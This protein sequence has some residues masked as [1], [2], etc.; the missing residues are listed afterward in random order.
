MRLHRLVGLLLCGA[1]LA[2]PA[3]AE[4]A[5]E[6]ER[7]ARER[8]EARLRLEQA[9]RGCQQRFVVTACVDAARAEHRQTM[10]RLRREEAVLDEAQRR[11]RAAARLSAIEEKQRAERARDAQGVAPPAE[12]A[13]TTKMPRQAKVRSRPAAPAASAAD[14][15]AEEQRKRSR[16]EERQRAAQAHREQAQQ[17]RAQREKAGRTSAPLPDPAAR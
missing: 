2:T 16:Y 14:R 12:T 8:S 15:G 6:R 9:Q 13:P 11:Q 5:A 17:R 7:I 4:E 1:T 10:M 3:R